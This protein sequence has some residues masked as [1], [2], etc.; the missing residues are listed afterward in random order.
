MKQLLSSIVILA[1]F[2]TAKNA[3]GQTENTL[4]FNDLRMV[5]LSNSSTSKINKTSVNLKALKDFSKSFHE[6]SDEKWFKVPGGV[7]AN[8][9]SKGIDF[10]I[11]YDENGKR[12]YKL[13]T[14]AEDNLPS[15]VRSLIRSHYYHYEI[16]FC[17][18]YQLSNSTVY[19]VKMDDD[20]SIK[21]VKIADGEIEVIADSK[22]N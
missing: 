21:T 1:L 2:A 7:I 19:V 9:L 16:E 13:L 10:R 4:A 17:N 18:E 8:F 15:D 22:R 6:V 20:K 14:Y 5:T 12:L 11:K 3:Q